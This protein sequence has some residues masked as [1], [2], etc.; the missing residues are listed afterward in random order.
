MAKNLS[1]PT[2]SVSEFTTWHQSFEEDVRLY[3]SLGVEGIE[4]LRSVHRQ[5]ADL[6]LNIVSD[7]SHDLFR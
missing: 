1:F 4:S 5:C 6:I 3:H 2:F 7:D